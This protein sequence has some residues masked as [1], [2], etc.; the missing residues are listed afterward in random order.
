MKN[1]RLLFYFLPFLIG[2]VLA[3]GSYLSQ[4]PWNMSLGKLKQGSTWYDVSWAREP[5]SLGKIQ[6]LY[7]SL[8]NDYFN[9]E[10]TLF[11]LPDL[12]SIEKCQE[13]SASLPMGLPENIYRQFQSESFLEKSSPDGRRLKESKFLVECSAGCLKD[14]SGEGQYAV[15]SMLGVTEEL[16][17]QNRA[18]LRMS[19]YSKSGEVLTEKHS[20]ALYDWNGF[21]VEIFCLSLGAGL[22]LMLGL[23]QS[24]KLYF[25][26]HLRQICNLKE[27]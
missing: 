3:T 27:T 17:D 2:V 7:C 9:W 8:S 16:P 12:L 20:W 21:V 5:I 24:S 13:V 26:K 25:L 1:K 14:Q 11:D 23:F 18:Y 4:Y 10:S 19:V 22:S 6:L 15:I